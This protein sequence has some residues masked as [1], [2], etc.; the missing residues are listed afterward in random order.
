MANERVYPTTWMGE[1][2]PDP[3]DHQLGF[4]ADPLVGVELP[5]LT[6]DKA[7]KLG[8]MARSPVPQL[9]PDQLRVFFRG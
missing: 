7:C 6:R 3:R 1:P 8:R 5:K 9:R 4:V 2:S